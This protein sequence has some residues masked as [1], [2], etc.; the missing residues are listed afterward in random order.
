M[1]TC[2]AS[3]AA[4]DAGAQVPP[5][6]VAVDGWTLLEYRTATS[7]NLLAAAAP[8][9]TAIRAA[10]QTAGRGRFQRQW[11]SDLG[12]LWLSAVVPT[13]ADAA[14][15]RPLPLAV[16]LAVCE[17]LSAGGVRGL[18]MRWPNDILVGD[19]KLAGLLIDQFAPGLAVAGIGLN[20]TNRPDAVDASLKDHTA[21]LA[22]L[23]PS[24]P[25]LRELTV[26][27]LL[28]LR[29][30]V[31]EMRDGGFSALLPRV[32]ALWGPP[33]SVELDLDGVIRRG[34]FS[35]VDAEG[36][37]ILL[38]PSGGFASCEPSEVRHLTEL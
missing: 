20:V 14:A 25:G 1:N 7:T 17:A 24:T 29:A 19:R 10:T 5:E 34:T 12:G 18:R 22:D 13:G 31:D 2:E 3:P 11:V 36:R 37:L 16:G 30:V 15:W 6:K 26:L 8:A 23:L 33:R 9:W 4:P 21:R 35:C 28:R 38:D 27:L 32:N